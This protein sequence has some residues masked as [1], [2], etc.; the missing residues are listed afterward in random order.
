MEAVL[1]KDLFRIKYHLPR[2]PSLSFNYS[3]EKSSSSSINKA[4]R[5]TS[6]IA[7][8]GL[9]SLLLA[10]CLPPDQLSASL[11]SLSGSSGGSSSGGTAPPVGSII[12]CTSGPADLSGMCRNTSAPTMGALEAIGPEVELAAA[13]NV[14][15]TEQQ[16]ST[17][18][19]LASDLP[20]GTSNFDASAP[21]ISYQPLLDLGLSTGDTVCFRIQAYDTAR[22]PYDWAEVQCTVV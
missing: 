20:S 7:F 13:L 8:V 18:S 4:F 9:C 15:A 16:V 11:S 21:S 1:Y 2:V 10:G 12:H 19:S 17:G 22:V 14:V 5:Y 3:L 6:N